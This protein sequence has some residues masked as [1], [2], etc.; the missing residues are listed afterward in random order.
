VCATHR[1]VLFPH[2]RTSITSDVT[3][4]HDK[5]KTARK[6]LNLLVYHDA[7]GSLKL[8]YGMSYFFALNCLSNAELS[9]SAI[10]CKYINSTL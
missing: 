8:R 5:G 9:L 1:Q 2:K 4:G 3:D 10:G 7:Q 6:W